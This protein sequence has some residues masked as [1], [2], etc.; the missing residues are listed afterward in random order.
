M[1]MLAFTISS[2]LVIHINEEL[3][4]DLNL[5]HLRTNQ[6]YNVFIGQY[7]INQNS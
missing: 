2:I 3:N 6:I 4:Q 1:Y 7:G 5:I